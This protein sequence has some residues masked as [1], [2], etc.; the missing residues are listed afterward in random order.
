MIMSVIPFTCVYT[1]LVGTEY[2]PITVILFIPYVICTLIMG[3]MGD[4]A[5][6]GDQV[7]KE[8]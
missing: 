7:C 5:Q 3:I 1:S 6:E 8:S 4:K 2:I